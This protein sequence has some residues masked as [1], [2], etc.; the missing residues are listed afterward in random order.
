MGSK[1]YFYAIQW[2][3]DCSNFKVKMRFFQAGGY[4]GAVKISALAGFDKIINFDM[5]GT[6]TD[7]S[8]Y[9]GEGEYERDFETL[10]AG[11]RMRTPIMRIHTV[12]AGGGSCVHF[13]GLRFRVGPESAGAN[14]GPACYRQGGPLTLTD[15]NVM[16]GRIQKRFFP[17]VFGAYGQEAIDENIV[18]D[19]LNA[20]T[21]EINQALVVSSSAFEIAEGFV[22][23]AIDNM[24]NAIKKI[25]VQRGYDV[26]EYTLCCFGA[27]AGQ[28][29]CLVAEALGIKTIFI[30]PKAGV[31]SAL[32]M[33]LADIRSLHEKAIRAQLN[34]TL[35][36]ELERVLK[37]LEKQGRNELYE[38]N[39]D[40]KNIT[41]QY[42]VHL[43]YTG[44][45]TT[46]L[47]DFASCADM[48]AAYDKVHLQHFGFVRHNTPLFVEAV[49]VEVI[50]VAPYAMNDEACVSMRPIET[51]PANPIDTVRMIC[52]GRIIDTTPVYL[53]DNL[54]I[55]QKITGPA[56]IVEKTGTT[57]IEPQWE[58]EITPRYDLILKAVSC[59]RS[60]IKSSYVHDLN[61]LK[62]TQA[63]TVADPILLEIFNNLFMSIASLNGGHSGEYGLFCEH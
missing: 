9:A 25:S 58:A 31:L 2:R 45:D 16:L 50:G 20:L 35:I 47:I 57:I 46:L 12:A 41:I 33:G 60:D 14:P 63:N 7:V 5:G 36:I 54:V 8:H 40:D 37:Q 48:K 55:D 1:I 43:R 30:H 27:A 34:E 17:K 28:H 39:I 59:S 11:V 56:I 61:H 22:K 13:D 42:K 29:A 23:I 51:I 6:S 62:V 3:I 15:C 19:K 32:G 52:N 21:V 53:R 4:V 24:A 44:T 18:K 49:S 26:T 10:V 38:Q